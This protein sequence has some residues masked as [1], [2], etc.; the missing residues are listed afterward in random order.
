MG[1][2][3]ELGR[4]REGHVDGMGNIRVGVDGAEAEM[5]SWGRWAKDADSRGEMLGKE[6]GRGG[7]TTSLSHLPIMPSGTEYHASKFLSILGPS[8]LPLLP[9][10]TFWE[11]RLSPG[12]TTL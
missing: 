8:I 10:F 6:R 11:T 7:C 12:D 3:G 2:R 5:S 9:L 4:R 1:R